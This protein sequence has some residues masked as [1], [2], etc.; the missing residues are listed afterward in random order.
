MDTILEQINTAYLK[1]QRKGRRKRLWWRGHSNIDWHLHPSIYHRNLIDAELDFIAR[2]KQLAVAI[3]PEL[4]T[5]QG[6]VEWLF[7]M[8]HHGLPTRLLDW[9]ESPLV[10][11]FFTVSDDSLHNFDGVIW[12]IDPIYINQVEFNEAKLFGVKNTEVES[13]ISAALH[14][15][16]QYKQGNKIAALRPDRTNL[17]Q[18]V[19]HA[20]CTIHGREQPLD[21]IPDIASHLF[22]VSVPAKEKIKIRNWLEIF[23]I[24][25]HFLFP[26][27]DNLAKYII[28]CYS[29]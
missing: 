2:F 18:F 20:Q 26:D 5:Q 28:D 3:Q 9:T 6:A 4:S 7:L 14:P 24:N 13:I 15:E 8:Q 10:A 17:R 29:P 23:Q 21:D 16:V 22:K 19:Q 1:A 12:G 11:L 25:R 27:L